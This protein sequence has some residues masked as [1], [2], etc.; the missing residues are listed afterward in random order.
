MQRLGGNT[1]NSGIGLLLGL[2]IFHAALAGIVLAA[3]WYGLRM[4]YMTDS[5][6]K[7]NA[8][9]GLVFFGGIA[10]YFIFEWYKAIVNKFLGYGL[11][12]LILAIPLGF[13]AF[14]GGGLAGGFLGNWAI[15]P[16]AA[17]GAWVGWL[18]LKR[19]AKKQEKRDEIAKQ[20]Q[21]YQQATGRTDADGQHMRGA[22]IAPAEWVSERTKGESGTAAGSIGGVPIPARLEP[23]HFMLS[24]GTGSGKSQAFFELVRY[25]RERGQ[26]GI[27]VDVGGEFLKRFW[28]PG[29]VILN[30]TDARSAP[31]SPLA[32]MRG[33]WD[34]DKISKSI[35]PDGV[36][37]EKEWTHYAQVFISA[38]LRRMSEA[39]DRRASEFVRLCTVG[40]NDELAALVAG[41]PAAALFNSGAEKM[42]A[43][44]RGI[45]GAYLAPYAYLAES[46]DAFSVK[47]WMQGEGDSWLFLTVRDDQ[48]S[49]L[50]PLI[51][52]WVDVAI[53]SLL[54]ME[55]DPDRRVWFLLDEFASLGRIQSVEALLTKA[56][57][58]G[59]VGVLGIQSVAQLRETY[60]QHMSQTLMSCLGTWAVLRAPDQETAEYMSKYL[61][62]EE[63]LRVLNNESYSSG[64]QSS[65]SGEGQSEQV[66]TRRLVMPSQLQSLP[67]LQ[68]YLNL[69]GDYPV[70]RIV[71]PVSDL[72]RNRAEGFI[73][74]E[75]FKH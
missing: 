1:G 58:Q 23:Y 36:G 51:A 73:E 10:A 33:A 53:S 37:A 70:C 34:A 61:G 60:G 54:S 9:F 68:G 71:V 28:K 45:V 67:D 6:G 46:E 15:I 43:S 21:D 14:W 16:G 57:K 35:V 12:A 2:T 8:L 29:D 48:L 40:S 63:V 4:E 30:P 27:V 18:F 20:W 62:E 32:E 5:S 47:E 11:V 13:A 69:I 42:L 19:L 31:W 39:G 38:I 75:R 65:S 50:K 72:P 55:P 3:A 74:A 49:T 41:L 44:V 7:G 66:A 64:G 59:G 56:R 25:A 52:C 17:A 26:R 22:Q 24:G